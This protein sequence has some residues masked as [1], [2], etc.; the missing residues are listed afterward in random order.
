LAEGSLRFYKQKLK[1][2]ADF[3]EAQAV[4]TIYQ[5]TP[6]FLR[7]FLLF[8]EEGGHNAGGRHG[9]FQPM[10]A[11]FLWYEDEVEPQGWS[12]PIRQEAESP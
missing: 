3:C 11:F 10:R 12:N 9:A 4:Q 5:I 6:S 8:L 2:F 1:L 7:Q